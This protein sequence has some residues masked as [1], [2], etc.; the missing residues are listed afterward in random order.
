MGGDAVT[1]RL[2]G[3][4]LV[5][6]TQSGDEIAGDLWI[7]GARIVAPPADGRNADVELALPGHLVMAGAID[8]HSHIAGGKVNLGRLL[9]ASDHHEH[10]E[11]ASDG[12]RGGGGLAT[13]ASFTT[14][15]RYAR[16]GYTTA[17][18]P[19]MVAA[20]ARAAHLEMAD[21]PILDKGAYVMLGNEEFLLQRLAA[22]A[23]QTEINDYV[24]WMVRA[25]AS[26]AVKVV[27]AGGISAF[28]FNG[29]GLDIDEPG[30]HHGV[31]PRTIIRTLARAVHELGI[32]HPL[33]VHC[34]NLGIPGNVET[35]LATIDAAE[36]FPIHLTHVQFHSYGTEG[37]RHF[38]SAAARIADAVNRNRNVSID[39]GQVVFG[40]TMTASGDTQAQFRNR[41]HANPDKWI[42]MDIECDAG[43]GL[44][45]F[46]YRDT[47]F[48]NA[49]QWAI[50]LELFLLV[51]DPWRVFLTTDHPNGG[52]FASYPQLV[53][54]LTERAFRD[55][56]LE[57]I[58]KAAQKAS[59]LG[60][61]TREYSLHEIAI[62]TR[63][64]PARSLGLGDRGRLSPGAVADI[65]VYRPQSDVEAMFR[66]PDRV[67]KSGI[68]V[69]RNGTILATPAGAT[70]LV[71]PGCDAQIERSLRRF[72][73]DHMTV[74]FDHFP[75]S[76][77]E[78]VDGGG[79]LA[80]H[81]CR[82]AGGLP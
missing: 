51:D 81:P 3:A 52:P 65:A 10:A 23:G 67:F 44:V 54:L 41:V 77:Q 25:T 27:N 28:K 4:R 29:R 8:I 32:P 80:E 42:S 43:C 61:L 76:A 31:T 62:M 45:P 53:R 7:D 6:P 21:V 33:H 55:E 35:T 59:V 5:D 78:I 9:A 60:G 30:P 56:C 75:L 36:G 19:A 71:R 14:G 17:F 12:L 18:E 46:R 79:R 49:L 20:N 26:H 13:P 34:N 50:G 40:A 15:Y 39:V 72:F 73:D 11:A 48:V 64:G 24:A 82:Q 70:Q 38:S 37:K 2:T 74:G 69:A 66:T 58:H 57:R 68:E 16:M 22:G 63:A 47:N 1:I